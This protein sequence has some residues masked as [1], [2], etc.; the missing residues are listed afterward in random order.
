MEK[1]VSQVMDS[2]M[3]QA[4]VSG[5]QRSDSVAAILA[6]I[7]GSLGVHKF[8]QGKYLTGVIFLLFFWTGIPGIFA[9]VEGVRLLMKDI[10]KDSPR[11]GM[12][13]SD[14]ESVSE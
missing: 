5:K 14:T 1:E 9:T 12:T 2:D 6:L 7:I 3:A 10:E 4:P 8:Y 13:I 11:Q